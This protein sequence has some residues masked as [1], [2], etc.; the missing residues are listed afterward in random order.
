MRTLAVVLGKGASKRLCC[1]LDGSRAEP[2]SSPPRDGL[3][4][5]CQAHE[6]LSELFL[7]E[8][9]PYSQLAFSD[10]LAARLAEQSGDGFLR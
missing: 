5:L 8:A 7:R 9:T 10:P 3:A 4:P 2:L 1:A 6:D